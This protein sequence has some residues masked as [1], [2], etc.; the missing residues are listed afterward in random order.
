MDR[1]RSLA[2]E[3]GQLAIDY[4]S[5]TTILVQL[6]LIA[7]LFLPAWF[8]SGWI[9][10]KLEA[11]ARGIKGMPGLLRIVIAFLRRFEW[12]FFAILLTLAY[13]AT[14]IAS[15]PDSN[16]LIYAAMLLSAAWLLISVVSHAMRSLLLRKVFAYAAWIYVAALILGISDDV[17]AVLDSAGFSLGSVRLSLLTALQAAL[18]LGVALWLSLSV[19]NFFDRRIQNIDEL[20]PSCRRSCPTSSPGSSS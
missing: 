7:L 11:R 18:L 16:Y 6:G 1:L 3:Y 15:W 10:P 19:G 9:E 5:Q 13:L 20:T 4:L 8:L 12:L 2:I 17:A 14:T